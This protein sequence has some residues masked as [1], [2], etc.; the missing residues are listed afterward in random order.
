[1]K[2]YLGRQVLFLR[3]LHA[4][5]A[6]GRRRAI[7]EVAYQAA[8]TGEYYALKADPRRRKLRDSWL[9]VTRR[10]EAVA[11]SH[12]RRP[13][14]P[15]ALFTAA[16]M[17]GDLSRISGVG[18]DTTASVDDYKLLLD[19]YPKHRLADDAAL[20]LAHAYLDRLNQPDAARRVLLRGLQ[21]PKGDQRAKLQTL[22]AS[23]RAEAPETPT[24]RA[25]ARPAPAPDAAPPERPV[26]STH[27]NAA[28]PP[29]ETLDPELRRP[30]AD[31]TAE[32]HLASAD[33]ARLPRPSGP[34]TAPSLRADLAPRAWPAYRRQRL[35]RFPGCAAFPT[36]VHFLAAAPAGAGIGSGRWAST[37][38]GRSPWPSSWDWIRRVVIDPGHGGH[39]TGTVGTEGTK[40]K[41]V[42]LAISRKLRTI[43]TEQGL[44][45]TLTREGDRFVRL[46]DRTRMA[47]IAR[48]DLFISVHCNS[49]PQ[50]SIRGIETYTLNLASDRFAIRLAARENAT[51]EKGLS[52]L[53]F[54]LADLATRAN[55]EESVRLASRVQAGLV[56]RL[57]SKERKIR[58]LGTKE[59]LFY[60]LL[61]TKMP[62]ILVETGFLS[63]PEEEKRLSTAGYR[64]RWP[65]PSLP[66]SRTSSATGTG[67]PR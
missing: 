44:E 48:A 24:R 63:N 59:A 18:E 8:R 60:V 31:R 49:L 64:T 41:D 7:A 33:V 17:L 58:D 25:E 65:A 67:W 22:L 39:D 10:F 15:D 32:R 23:V 37:A 28:P 13:R 57:A 38:P 47:N 19:S 27:A 2:A 5:V 40:E 50:K 35:P 54:L 62:A 61:G 42:A 16:Q 6:L 11:K 14:A 34:P 12:P 29:A 20:A 26:S 46:E 3:L 51:S 56:N 36:P 9:T 45:V 53:Q 4:H 21:L 30:A 43:L 66:A 1:M 55:T 52:D